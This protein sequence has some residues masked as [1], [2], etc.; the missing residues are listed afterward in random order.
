MLF[1]PKWETTVPSLAGLIA[2]LETKNPNQSYQWADCSG[3]CLIG[4]Y[5]AS[6]GI[7]W[8][9]VERSDEGEDSIYFRLAIANDSLAYTRPHTFGGAL[10]RARAALA[11][12][13]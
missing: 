3:R 11:A 12:R 4:Q 2:W 7:S 10:K 1:N 8:E 5:C 9:E 6:L 13:K